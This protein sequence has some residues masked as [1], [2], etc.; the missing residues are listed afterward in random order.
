MR[1]VLSPVDD[2]EY[3]FDSNNVGHGQHFQQPIQANRIHG[4]R[5]LLAQSRL[6]IV[7]HRESSGAHH[8]QVVRAIANGNDVAGEGVVGRAGLNLRCGYEVVGIYEDKG[9][10]GVSAAHDV[11]ACHRARLMPIQASPRVKGNS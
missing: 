10:S 4:R 6:S 2:Y 7:R 11:S 1:M 3:Q 8:G 5:R 9:V